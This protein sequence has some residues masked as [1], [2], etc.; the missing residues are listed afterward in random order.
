MLLQPKGHVSLVRPK[1]VFVTPRA[2]AT[3]EIADIVASYGQGAENAKVAGFDGS[4]SMVPTAICWISFLQDG[5]N[6][7]TDAY[8]GPVEN[9][10]RLMLE[11]TDAAISIWG[12]K[13][14]GM[15]LAPRGDAHDMGD[16]NPRATFGYVALGTRQTR[17]R[18]HLRP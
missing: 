5:A 13:R 18:L 2:L 7:R 14:V 15:H 4:K 17:H 8:G 11:V 9:R 6:Q 16:S 1:K 3:S 12:A 10:A